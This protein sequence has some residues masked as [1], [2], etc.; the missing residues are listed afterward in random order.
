MTAR[1]LVFLAATAAAGAQDPAQNRPVWE[2]TWGE[3]TPQFAP[4]NEPAGTVSL[5]ELRNPVKR[6][7]LDMIVKAEEQLKSGESR[8]GIETLMKIVDDPSAAPYALGILGTEHLKQGMIDTA[9]VELAAAVHGLPANHATQSNLAYALML[10]GRYEE[11][12]EHARTAVRLE[13]SSSR[14]RYVLAQLLL[15]VDSVEEA[16]FHL[17]IA[18]EELPGARALLGQLTR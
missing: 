7:Y 13:A 2:T 8:K 15:R 16:R 4:R 1:T 11:G 12:L 10:K 18:A 17:R 9:L 6:K 3:P 5:A 14:S